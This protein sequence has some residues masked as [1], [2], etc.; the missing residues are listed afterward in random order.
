MVKE[1]EREGERE[2]LGIREDIKVESRRG[3]RTAGRGLAWLR[4]VQTCYLFPSVLTLNNL[5]IV[6]LELISYMPCY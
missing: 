1:E 2:A 5:Q 3:Q 6:S 4:Q